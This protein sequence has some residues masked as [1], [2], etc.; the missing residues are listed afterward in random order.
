MVSK[1]RVKRKSLR[2]RNK[3][4]I[5]SQTKSRR[6]KNRIGSKNKR[7]RS[8]NTKKRKGGAEANITDIGNLKFCMNKT[9]QKECGKCHSIDG[10]K[11]TLC[12]YTQLKNLLN[13]FTTPK[14]K[15]KVDIEKLRN[16][17]EHLR[18]LKPKPKNETNDKKNVNDMFKQ[19]IIEEIKELLSEDKLG[20]MDLCIPFNDELFYNLGSHTKEN[21]RTYG[22]G[23]TYLDSLGIDRVCSN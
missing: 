4:N 7:S 10:K 22:F 23:E 12:Q 2:L 5:R 6:S 15:G 16:F 11:I 19:E 14:T 17:L 9:T 20:N 18:E 21:D 1:K 3:R 13:F 8:R